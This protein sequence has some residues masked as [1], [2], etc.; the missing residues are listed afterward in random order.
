[1][2]Y[3]IVH[4]ISYSLEK[5]PYTSKMS[6]TGISNLLVYRASGVLFTKLNVL[7]AK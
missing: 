5:V 1:M 3:Y 7:S 4:E 2:I 6:D